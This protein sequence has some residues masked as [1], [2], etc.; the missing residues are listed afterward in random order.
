[1]AVLGGGVGRGRAP[2]KGLPSGVLRVCR[3]RSEEE[4]VVGGGGK[5]TEGIPGTYS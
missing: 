1:V 5:A 4:E 3:H 2:R